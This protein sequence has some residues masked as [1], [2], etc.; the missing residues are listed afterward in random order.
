MKSTPHYG[1]TME[2]EV[3]GKLLF[4]GMAIIRNGLRLDTKVYV[5]PT[6]IGLLLQ[7]QSHVVRYKNSLLKTI[8]NRG[9]KSPRI[10]FISMQRQCEK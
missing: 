5:K 1:F 10:G 9:S 8:L 6:D 7:Y 4:L 2:L 3:N